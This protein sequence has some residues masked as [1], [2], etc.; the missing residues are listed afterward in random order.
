MNV[1]VF[2]SLQSSEFVIQYSIFLSKFSA[3]SAAMSRTPTDT[4]DAIR[5][6]HGPEP[7]GLELMAER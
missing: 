4:E 2:S 3:F 7:F 1:E 5:Q 6:A